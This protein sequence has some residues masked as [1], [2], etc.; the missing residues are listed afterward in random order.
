MM[1]EG[2]GDAFGGLSSILEKLDRDY[3]EANHA[4]N[5]HAAFL[6]GP[7][8][9][10]P[11]TG[12]VTVAISTENLLLNAYRQTKFGLPPFLCVDTTHRLMIASNYCCSAHTPAGER[13]MLFVCT[14]Y[15]CLHLCCCCL[16]VLIGTMSVTQHFHTIAYGLCSHEDAAA[17]QYVFR[18]V[19]DAVDAVVADR[20]AKGLR[21]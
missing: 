3:L 15:S 10:V 13:E 6:L 20:A 11:E 19:F 14:P 17:H 12:R 18:Q 21:I 5:E 2:K 8:L 7:P 1:T 16:A 4:F 9:V